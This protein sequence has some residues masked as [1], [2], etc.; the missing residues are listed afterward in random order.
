[1]FVRPLNPKHPRT[2]L[3]L[4]AVVAMACDKGDDK[5]SASQPPTKA[6]KTEP[7]AKKDAPPAEQERPSEASAKQEKNAPV[8]HWNAFPGREEGT[9]LTIEV[10]SD[11]EVPLHESPGG[12]PISDALA[13]AKGT[14]IE[15]EQRALV[16]TEPLTLTAKANTRL[17]AAVYSADGKVHGEWS[18]LQLAPASQIELYGY[19]G[20][21]MCLI[22]HEGTTYEANCPRADD[23]TG[24]PADSSGGT[25]QKM[26]P[27]A[28]AFWIKLTNDG[29]SGWVE[30]RDEVFTVKTERTM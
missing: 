2:L 13:L 22:G 25:A 11:A 26:R 18:K 27:K 4:V 3:P 15:P 20:E 10:Q 6:A 17:S 1:M 28:A 30:V 5:A 24:L 12:A 14:T 7:V 16:V 19:R 21:G 9:K 23:F 29:K 8:V